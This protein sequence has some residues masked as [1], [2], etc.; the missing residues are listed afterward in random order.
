M[1]YKTFKEYSKWFSQISAATS[2]IIIVF[3]KSKWIFES[4]TAA[5]KLVLTAT[6]A[7]ILALIFGAVSLPRWQ[8]FVA[9]TVFCYVAY[10]ILFTSLYAIL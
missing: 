3:V 5:G 9:L 7:A 1:N 4:G 10:S 6:I 2:F 8:G